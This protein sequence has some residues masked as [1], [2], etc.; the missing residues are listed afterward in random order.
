M[1][2]R[3]ILTATLATTAALAGGLLTAVP[4]SAVVVG[5]VLA[6]ES[7]TALGPPSGPA[8]RSLT[9][10]A[11]LNKGT[12]NGDGTR[13]LVYSCAAA[14]TGDVVSVALTRCALLVNGTQV[15]NVPLASPGPVV[16]S[17]NFKLSTKSASTVSVCAAAIATF[18]DASKL[19]AST[20][21]PPI[22][23]G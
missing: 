12:A 3:R 14:A 20:C 7:F 22:K 17:G 6:V 23:L 2:P 1:S 4:A 15:Q 13:S 5:D 8:G 16:A 9:V 11:Q 10:T 19:T 18:L 21:T